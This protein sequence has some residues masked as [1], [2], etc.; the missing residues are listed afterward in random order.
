MK[1]LAGHLII[2]QKKNQW[3]ITLTTKELVFQKPHLSY[4]ILLDDIIGII[5]Y[6]IN[7][8]NH[9]FSEH[10]ETS[11]EPFTRHY[12]KLT[13]S[14]LTMIRRQGI[15]HLSSTDLIISLNQRI[16][17]FLQKYTSLTVMYS[18]FHKQQ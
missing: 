18:S 8:G 12:Y 5:P 2:S 3:G 13:L 11:V 14:A 1:Q 4:H 7:K 15:T 16:L 17:D 9:P 6:E 10:I